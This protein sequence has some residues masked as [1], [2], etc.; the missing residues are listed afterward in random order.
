M[1]FGNFVTYAAGVAGILAVGFAIGSN[2]ITGN[3]EQLKTENERLEKEIGTINTNFTKLEEETKILRSGNEQLQGELKQC[4]I[5]A[6]Y[7]PESLG[8]PSGVPGRRLTIPAGDSGS[9][10]SVSIS[11]PKIEVLYDPLRYRVTS[12]F[13]SATGQSQEAQFEV[14]TSL[15]YGGFEVRLLKADLTRAQFSVEKVSG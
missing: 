15:T 7:T 5:A 10:E 12:I 2:T 1:T 8:N 9:V 3:K 13:N 14:G 11:I 6:V 4:Q